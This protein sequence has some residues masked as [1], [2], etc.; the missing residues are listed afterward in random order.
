MK[1]TIMRKT[2]LMQMNKPHSM[3]KMKWTIRCLILIRKGKT[4]GMK[5]VKVSYVSSLNRNEY[6][7]KRFT[8]RG[9][10]NVL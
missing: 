4:H 8:K 7:M 6:L 5:L 1:I 2:I 9:N 10:V 3:F